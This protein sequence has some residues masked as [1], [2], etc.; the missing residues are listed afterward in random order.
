MEVLGTSHVG[1]GIWEYMGE[2]L[3]GGVPF[4]HQETFALLEFKIRD[5]VHT[6][7]EFLKYCLSVYP[8]FKKKIQFTAC[9]IHEWID[10]LGTSHV[11]RGIPKICGRGVFCI[12]KFRE[13]DPVHYTS[14]EFLKYYLSKI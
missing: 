2:G 7:G 14:G 10:A 3:G 6:C 8:K 11:G 12:L 9:F 5:L 13:S 1:R 4:L